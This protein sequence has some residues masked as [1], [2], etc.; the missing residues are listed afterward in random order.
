M[1]SIEIIS[2]NKVRIGVQLYRLFTYE[3]PLPD[4]SILG[5]EAFGRPYGDCQDKFSL[6]SLSGVLASDIPSGFSFSVYEPYLETR[7]ID[8]IYFKNIADQLIF[9][10]SVHHYYKNWH[11]KTNLMQLPCLL[12]FRFAWYVMQSKMSMVFGIG[13]V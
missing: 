10:F 1:A 7:Q 5:V 9:G 12:F 11:H 6:I 8:N 4:G 3:H 2:S 13:A